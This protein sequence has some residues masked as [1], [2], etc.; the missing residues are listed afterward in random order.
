MLNY[1]G[2][3]D[4]QLKQYNEAIIWLD[5]ALVLEPNQ[6]D[7]YVNRAIAKEGMNDTTA[8]SDYKNAILLKPDH[9][10]ALN[11]L[12]IL[13]RKQGDFIGA[14]DQLEQAIGSDS[15]MFY[16]YLERAYQ[17]MEGGYY[18]GAIDDY[19]RAIAI[20]DKDAEIWFNRGLAKEKQK[21][22]NGAYMDYTKAIELNE[23]LVKGWLGRG[24]IL[25]KQAKYLEAI[26]DYN[27]AILFQPDYALAFYN[28][29]ITKEK[30]K[31]TSDACLDLKRA[32]ELGLKSEARMM[33]KMCGE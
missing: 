22:W 31:Q 14:D 30:M 8:E 15:S 21:D 12:S 33:Q 10:I 9:T 13:K 26:E 3:V 19:T 29:A 25:T 20:N 16:T 7:Y 5:S 11:N 17:R 6:P 27:V 32:I 4:T 28:R 1:L 18:K 24:N 23:K 2:M